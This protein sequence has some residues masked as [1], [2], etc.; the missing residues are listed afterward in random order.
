MQVT[1]LQAV[2]QLTQ[3]VVDDQVQAG[4]PPAPPSAAGT[5]G[6]AGKG[7]AAQQQQ[8]QHA[9]RNC[10]PVMVRAR[11]PWP[12]CGLPTRGLERVRT[13]PTRQLAVRPRACAQ[14]YSLRRLARGVA[15]GRAASRQGYATALAALLGAPAQQL[16]R[17]K[18]SAGAGVGA[19]RWQIAVNEP[20]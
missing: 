1:R 14:T 17:Q 4:P 20:Q 6:T 19:S 3:H 8:L 10:S 18:Q 9:L 13:T 12:L 5:D 2:T 16:L 15:S 7:K 11:P